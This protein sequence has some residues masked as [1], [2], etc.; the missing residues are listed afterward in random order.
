MAMEKILRKNH[1]VYDSPGTLN[2]LYVLLEK[3]K[4]VYFAPL[5]RVMPT[6]FFKGYAW[7]H[8]IP[9]RK[10]LEAGAFRRVEKKDSRKKIKAILQKIPVPKR[11]LKKLI[12]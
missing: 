7:S 4:S 6:A 12:S 10:Y 1:F 8:Y 3:D 2:E 5:N 9:M 11:N